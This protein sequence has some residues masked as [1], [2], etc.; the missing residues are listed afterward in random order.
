MDPAVP[1]VSLLACAASG[2]VLWESLSPSTA[3]PPATYVALAALAVAFA[4]SR[5]TFAL[6]SS[7]TGEMRFPTRLEYVAGGCFLG[8]IG[9]AL[10]HNE[11][12]RRRSSPD[13]AV[14]H[15]L[16]L[17]A[18]C[19]GILA[20]WSPNLMSLGM[21]IGLYGVA[22]WAAGQWKRGTVEATLGP[23]SLLL[24]VALLYNG[25]ATFNIASLG[26]FLWQHGEPQPLGLYLGL[27]L[28]LGGIVLPTG[29]I[30]PFGAF[31]EAGNSPV[32][33]LLG[34][35]VL[36]RLGL[37]LGAVAWECF[38][39]CLLLSLAC[40]AWG[41]AT[42]LSQTLHDPLRRIWGLLAAQRGFLL[43][44]LSFVFR[45]QD[46]ALLVTVAAAYTLVQSVARLSLRWLS[47]TGDVAPKRLLSSAM[48]EMPLV[49]V[50]LCL[51][52]LSLIG[53]PPTLCFIVRAEV[54]RLAWTLGLT[55]LA[56]FVA[57]MSILAFWVLGPWMLPLLRGEG[58]SVG[59][60]PPWPVRI[61]LMLAAI[62]LV[63]LGLFPLPLVQLAG[64]LVGG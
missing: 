16:P 34:L 32:S 56:P 35:L 41:W 1:A 10:L 26:R 27:G 61:A 3:K 14:T 60:P 44:A 15:A 52:L 21:G 24:G 59:L 5:R 29:L 64:W 2:F 37:H 30:P 39:V 63:V 54:V 58:E 33:H 62:C 47:A 20:L 17:V 22:W 48:V 19:G 45:G 53:L 9:I 55:W 7:V 38:W 36:L 51:A 6:F 4:L 46:L 13:V 18:A 57:A 8:L 11:M 23:L 50:P 31:D 25:T 49:G 28:V 43:L 12:L 40:L 42:A